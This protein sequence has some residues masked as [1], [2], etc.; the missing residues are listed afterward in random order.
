[1]TEQTYIGILAGGKGTRFWPIS[2]A[3]KPKQFLD[4]LN[5]GKTLIQETYDRAKGF[6]KEENVRIITDIAY[7]KIIKEQIPEIKQ[8]QLLLEPIG[9]NTAPSIAYMA[10]K[11]H[12][13]N[14]NANIII[15]PSD[16]YIHP[17]A[18]FYYT[19]NIIL[20][21]LEENHNAIFTIGITPTYPATGYGYIQLIKDPEETVSQ[22]KYYKVK[23]FTEKPVLEIAK[24]FLASGEFLWNSGM[25]VFKAGAILEKFKKF[26]PDLYELFHSHY[27]AFNTAEEAKA[28]SEIY[29]KCL[30]NS[31]DF[32]IMEHAD[33]VFVVP[34]KFQWSDVGT[35]KALYDISEKDENNNVIQMEETM[36]EDSKNNLF[37]SN[38]KNKF[39]AIKGLQ[40]FILVDTEDALLLLPL[41]EDQF[42]KQIVK[43]LQKANKYV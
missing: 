2:R 29:S 16:H 22:D 27:E 30:S 1:M 38:V 34:S 42:V 36:I 26:M 14:P 20:E 15:L 9:R 8:E 13:I 7:D 41:S 25:F 28:I 11:I 6:V 23:T 12:K 17:N 35:W 32:G 39:Y 37:V 43:K 18:D 31:F 40:D 3:K 33:E 10:F 19:L 21:G 24:K 5:S 4:I